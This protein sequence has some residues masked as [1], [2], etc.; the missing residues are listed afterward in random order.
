MAAL[1]MSIIEACLVAILLSALFFFFRKDKSSKGFGFL[2]YVTLTLVILQVAFGM[3]LLVT[4]S[5]LLI[6]GYTHWVI[7]LLY[8]T[9]MS[10]LLLAYYIG[11]Y[12]RISTLLFGSLSAVMFVLMLVDMFLGLPLSYFYNAYSG[13]GISYL[14]GFGRTAMSSAG[15]STAFVALLILSLSTLLLSF[16]SIFKRQHS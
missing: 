14:L 9:T 4:D 2:G 13:I 8:V 11:K 6:Y 5:V 3:Y 12:Y 7:L 16:Y 15:I 1:T 10:I